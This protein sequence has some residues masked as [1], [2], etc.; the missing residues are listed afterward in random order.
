MGL[1]GTIIVSRLL[2]PK[3][4]GIFQLAF[5]FSTLVSTLR[6]FGLTE[7]VIQEKEM[8]RD[9]LRTALGMNILLSYGLGITLF[10][11]SWPL[12]LWFREPVVGDLIRILCINF[13]FIPFGAVSIAY[14]K[15][16]LAFRNTMWISIIS[17]ALAQT[18]LVCGVLAGWSY[19]SMVA[20]ALV[21]TVATVVGANLLKDPVVPLRPSFR[22]LRGQFRFG[23][24]AMLIYGCAAVG[25]IFPDQ[26]I[27][28]MFGSVSVAM[29][30]RGMSVIELFQLGV[31]RAALMLAMPLFSEAARDSA[32]RA[33]LASANATALFTGIGWTAAL[34]IAILARPIMLGIFGNQWL[35]AVPIAKLLCL[36]LAFEVIF[37]YYR[38]ILIAFGKIGVATQLQTAMLVSRL[39]CF[40]IGIRWGLEGGAIGLAV[41]SALNAVFCAFAFHRHDLIAGRMTL[42][43]LTK[44]AVVAAVSGAA[45]LGMFNVLDGYF[46]RS[47]L[48][49]LGL[50]L[51]CAVVVACVWFAALKLTRHPLLALMQNALKKS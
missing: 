15:R 22:G 5:L 14:M 34:C 50:L 4:I 43:V 37:L 41:S 17:I 19:Y 44:S 24:N 12:A 48:Q 20:S 25:R 51:S 33:P 29:F 8:T 3:E 30:S 38:E 45:A 49:Q 35:E 40:A 13:L 31:G 42:S 46:A 23:A 7:F 11:A 16:T 18:A 39:V 36:A 10:F 47:S 27:G 2:P 21:G 9:K 1:F 32:R 6:D 28:R 26:L